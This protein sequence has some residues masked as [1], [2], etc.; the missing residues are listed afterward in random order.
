[1]NSDVREPEIQREQAAALGTTDGSD[2]L[3]G[4]PSQPLLENR[5]RVVPVPAEQLADLLG[6]VLVDLDPDY[7]AP[8]FGGAWRV[9]ASSAA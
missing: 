1:M 7:A 9:R 5:G 3:I 4:R 8:G 6:Q 2:T